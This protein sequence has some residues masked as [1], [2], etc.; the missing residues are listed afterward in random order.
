M[1]V[2]VVDDEE[3]V[4]FICEIVLG[5]NGIPV[6][7]AAS[8]ERALALLE[9]EAASVK[10]VITDYQMP[11]TRGDELLEEVHAR[12][13]G[14][15]TLLWSAVENHAKGIALKDPMASDFPLRVKQLVAG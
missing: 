7:S 15:P 10:L 9:Q 14:L 2:L 6:V 5:S 11:E 4:R 3:S 12:F 8:A 1:S 13:P